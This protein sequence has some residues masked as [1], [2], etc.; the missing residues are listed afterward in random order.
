MSTLT[1]TL[2]AP[3]HGMCGVCSYGYGD[4]KGESDSASYKAETTGETPPPIVRL[5]REVFASLL[6]TFPLAAFHSLHRIMN[7]W[8]ENLHDI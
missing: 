5:V 1:L 6:G 8:F 2:S 3:H 7:F 4:T